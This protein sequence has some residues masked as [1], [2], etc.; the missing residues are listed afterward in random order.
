MT[1]YVSLFPITLPTTL[2]V[3]AQ[4]DRNP[5]SVLRLSREPEWSQQH[6][7]IMGPENSFFYLGPES[8]AGYVVYGNNRLNI[9]MTYF[10]RKGKREGSL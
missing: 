1:H 4:V 5:N 9:G 6:P 3:I 8:S 10:L 7:S 2:R